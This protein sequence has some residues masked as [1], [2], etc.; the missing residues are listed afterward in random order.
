MKRLD[1]IDGLRGIAALLVFLIHSG[2]LGLRELGS[3]GN[4]FVDY[5]KYGV[6]LFFVISGY[7]LYASEATSI[8]SLRWCFGFATKRLLRIAPMYFIMLFFVMSPLFT[9]HMVTP[10]RMHSFY[11]HISFVNIILPQYSNDLLGV[12]WSIPVEVA[13]YSLFPLFFYFHKKTIIFILIISMLFFVTLQNDNITYAMGDIYFKNRAHFFVAYLF[14]FLIGMLSFKLSYFVPKILSLKM[15]IFLLFTVVGVSLLWIMMGENGLHA[16]IVVT[17]LSSITILF[18]DSIVSLKL[19]LSH[20]IFKFCGK[21]SFSLYLIHSSILGIVFQ[22]SVYK[23]QAINGLISLV[24]A[25]A[26]ATISYQ[27]IEKPFINFAHLLAKLFFNKN[28]SSRMSPA[29]TAI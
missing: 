27:I 3:F 16:Q 18:A 5:A 24:V 4:N 15:Q 19:F 6:I 23:S 11:C 9:G 22:Y 25:V 1:Y 8:V 20:A 14:S 17:L 29:D 12:E 13:F 2:G 10:E 28:I 7:T 21:I 26:I